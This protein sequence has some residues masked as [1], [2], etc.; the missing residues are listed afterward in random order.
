MDDSIDDLDTNTSQ[1][2]DSYPFSEYDKVMEARGI[3][4]EEDI[5]A[6]RRFLDSYEDA[7][8]TPNE[9]KVDFKGVLPLVSNL[10]STITSAMGNDDI[11][12]AVGGINSVLNIQE[13][14]IKKQK[15][16]IAAL[17][18]VVD[19]QR[20]KISSLEGVVDGQKTTIRTQKVKIA[21]LEKLF[22]EQDDK[23]EVLQDTTDKQ[24]KQILE[25]ECSLKNQDDNFSTK[26]KTKENT[27]MLLRGKMLLGSAAFNFVDAAVQTVYG[28]DRWKKEKSLK[29]LHTY[30][31]IAAHPKTKDEE[32]KWNLFTDAYWHE[33]TDEIICALKKVRLRMAHPVTVKEEDELL[34]VP[35]VATP[36]ELKRIA[37]LLYIA[38]KQHP[39]RMKIE[40]LIDNLGSITRKLGRDLLE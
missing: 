23:I 24:N 9:L 8:N 40:H 38:K 6:L 25:L 1:E 5:V 36:D 19:E 15:E 22:G 4:N 35:P 20:T 12:T 21:G 10:L 13:I 17:E 11:K 18:S 28:L 16:D 7:V 2:D 34:E 3:A 39:T 26:W 37:G 31:D 14:Q 32:E 29:K 33:D 27:A 30:E